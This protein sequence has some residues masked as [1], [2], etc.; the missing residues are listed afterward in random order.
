MQAAI[1]EMQEMNHF[2]LLAL[3]FM[4]LYFLQQ[5]QG[6]LAEPEQQQWL[7][8]LGKKLMSPC[9]KCCALNIKF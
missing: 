4:K 3:P 9:L 8:I 1:K 2:L 5:C 6:H 7:T